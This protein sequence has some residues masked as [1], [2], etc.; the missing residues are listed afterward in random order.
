M[1]Q[2]NDKN[3]I[4][5][6]AEVQ[7]EEAY[8]TWGDDL[9]SK[10]EALT[11]SSESM[12]EYTLIEHSSAMRRYGL[13]YSNLDTNT[14]G[15]PGLT[16]RDYD[17]FRPDEAIPGKIKAILKKAEDIYQ[18][19]G[20]V[21]NVIDLM[22]D[23]GSQ[24]IKISHPN[25]KIERFY[26]KWFKKINGK[27]R[28][29]RFLNN[30][31]KTGNVVVN[32]Q[33]GKIS[34]K[35]ADKLYKTAASPDFIIN[36]DEDLKVEKRE[37][38]WRYTFIDPFYVDISAGALSSF[39]GIKRYEL[40]LPANLRKSINN[41]K[42]ES[43]KEVI[44]KLPPEVIEAAKNRKAYPL[45]PD[46]ILVF[47]YK[48]DDWQSWAYPMIYSI[49]DDITVIEKL[50]LAD[51]AAL[52]GAISNIRIFKLGSLEHKIA[53][54]K[55]AASKLAQ[56]LGNNVGGGTMDLVWGPD[57]ELLESKTNVHQFLGE[58]KYTPHLNS[59]YAGLGIPPTLTGT[60]GAAGTTNNFISLK[61]LTQRLQYGRDVL[62]T[63][64]EKEIVIVQKAMGF[65]EPAKIEFD[66]MDLSNEEVEKALLIQLA[67]RNL[68]SDELLQ[69]RFGFDS[70][71]EKTR[72][73]R[74]NRERK[75]SRMSKKAGPWYDPEPENS[76]KKIALQ[77]GIATPSEVGLELNEK[78][79]GE[80]TSLEM[81]Q[82][83]RPP[84][85]AKDSTESLPCE[86]QQG[87]PKLS[88]DTQKRKTREFK[89]QT[90]AKITV[91]ANKAQDKINEIINPV[92]LD[93]FNKKNL[94]SL[95]NEESRELET[96][97]TA[98]LFNLQPFC[99]INSEKILACFEDLNFK[100]IDEYSVWLKGIS[101]KFDDKLTVDDQK[102]AKASFYYLIH[103]E[104]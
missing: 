95:S 7:N 50:K 30:L 1:I 2:K 74:E 31:Y 33:T 64:W 48:K 17:F 26:R 39:S 21:K 96:I 79:K 10:Q 93:F 66:R 42:N 73:N 57:I 51:M 77:S 23:F 35:V 45:N 19:V 76:L 88:R 40:N 6:N 71:M 85:S 62:A 36:T 24:G 22:G 14:S 18:R 8:V 34:L 61:T 100:F 41:P 103:N 65:K 55:A 70:D 54:T 60:Y 75:S 13:D 89:P 101:S 38:P 72:I 15:R 91:W 83:L 84:Q 3:E 67:D 59:V 49:M 4:I 52:D 94:R 102:N 97:K 82:N 78:K 5:Q 99:T 44:S 81:R 9:Q 80:K 69:N 28:S 32:R 16:R 86:P 87:R 98:I 37:I 25:K 90:G 11:K 47:H 63:F 12:S 56:I 43:E 68:V 29:E 46:K 53:P 58:A 20:L 104:N 92:M 27:D